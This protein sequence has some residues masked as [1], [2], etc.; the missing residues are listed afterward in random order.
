MGTTAPACRIRMETPTEDDFHFERCSRL[1][2]DSDMTAVGA[3]VLPLDL[4]NIP[5]NLPSSIVNNGRPT[6]VPPPM[7]SSYENGPFKLL[8]HENMS[9]IVDGF[10]IF[11]NEHVPNDL[12]KFLVQL[13]TRINI[14]IADMKLGDVFMY[15]INK[16]FIMTLFQD[17]VGD[18]ITHQDIA[19]FLDVVVSMMTCNASSSFIIE[20]RG[21]KMLKG[22]LGDR[23]PNELNVAKFQQILHKITLFSFK[24]EGDTW[25]FTDAAKLRTLEDITHKCNSI[26]SSEHTFGCSDDHMVR[27]VSQRHLPK[28]FNN[29]KKK[30]GTEYLYCIC[31]TSCVR[32]NP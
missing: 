3:D 30:Y 21:T 32:P 13:Q 9:L 27:N 26:F 24:Q 2:P 6:H 7:D 5:D 16:D 20:G 17:V 23:Q 1:Y 31:L 10:E 15:F 11:A 14:P 19:E 28:K 4:E 12:Q 25:T 18:G 29:K 22:F 8:S